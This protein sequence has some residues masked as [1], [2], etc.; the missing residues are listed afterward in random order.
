M[1]LIDTEQAQD[2]RANI[3]DAR[4]DQRKTWATLRQQEAQNKRKE[5]K[6][7]QADLQ[8]ELWGHMFSTKFF[9]HA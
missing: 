8:K 4:V 1:E 5:K 3:H 6:D 9:Q 2:M 7:E